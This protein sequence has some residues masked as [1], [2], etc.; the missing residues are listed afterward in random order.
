MKN[1]SVSKIE[2]YLTCPYNF[3]LSYVDKI[4][5]ISSGTPLVGRVIHDIV[6]VALKEYGRTGKYPD[7]K[8]LDDRF[9][10]TYR[11]F[12]EK[13]ESRDT[14][15]GW[16]WDIPESDAKSA[17]RAL[18]P[19]AREALEEHRP[20]M[21]GSGPA[22]EQRID[23]EF[24]SEVGQVPLIG[25][26][27]LLN[28]S[29]VLCDWKSTLKDTPSKLAKKSWLQFSCYS[30][31][32]WPIIGEESQS[33]KKIFLVA[34]GTPHVEVEPFTVGQ[35][36]REYFAKLAAQVW[37]AIHFGVYP[38]T[39]SWKCNPKFCP[40]FGPCKSEVMKIIPEVKCVGCEKTLYD[41]SNFCMHCG[42]KVEAD[43][44][45]AAEV[46]A[47]AAQEESW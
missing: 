1:L 5:Q 2:S 12:V 40:F 30:F 19:V 4:P 28:E 36:H 9:E 16:Q 23:L 27:D 7:R 46:A 31:W 8:T 11:R 15:M 24:D 26:V 14:F 45:V 22:V 35:K 32:S 39:D 3:K 29:G 21:L 6:E 33:C 38:T 37:K 43:A 44:A 17:Y 42:L 10:P 20:W 47:Q 41:G 25:Y 34:G 18:I 13:E